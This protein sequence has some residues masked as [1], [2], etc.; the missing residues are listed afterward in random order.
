MNIVG[1]DYMRRAIELARRGWGMTS[2]NPMV[3]AVLVKENR[4]IG[5]GWHGFYG[6]DHAEIVSIKNATEST[7]SSSL[8]VNLEPC[9]HNGKT[10]PCVDA[11][12]KARIAKVYCSMKDPNKK[13]TGGGIERLRS[14]GVEVEVGMYEKEAMELNEIY[15]KH[16]ISGNPFVMLKSAVSMDGR[17]ADSKRRSRW[18]SCP[19]SLDLSHRLRKGYDA[20]LV[21]I[22]TVLEDN[23]LLNVRVKEESSGKKITRVVIDSALRMPCDALMLETLDDGEIFIIT[24]DR[25]PD[26]RIRCME[27]TGAKVVDLGKEGRISLRETTKYLAAI[28]ITSVLIEGGSEIAASALK[29]KIV[30]KITVIIA[31]L[32]IG[33]KNSV[34]FVGGDGFADLSSCPRIKNTK[35][36]FSGV[37]T[38]MI[39]YPDYRH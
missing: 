24:S 39:G 31:P 38:V 3:G 20:V 35:T 2:P 9:N 32:I 33:G 18:M 23:P 34:P 1:L 13:V 37:D 8:Y 6:G 19:E 27:S 26:E 29:E 36:F 14:E 22:G 16:I 25:A 7:E 17:I 15:L 11:I 30:D 4:I 5:E 10:P 28:G 12:L 21:G